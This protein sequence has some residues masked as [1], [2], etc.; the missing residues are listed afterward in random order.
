MLYTELVG[1]TAANCMMRTVSAVDF[2][3][4]QPLLPKLEEVDMRRLVGAKGEEPAVEA[5]VAPKDASEVAQERSQKVGGAR[6]RYL[7]RKNKVKR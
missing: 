4:L 7:A 3:W 5:V 1:S 6:E 2:R